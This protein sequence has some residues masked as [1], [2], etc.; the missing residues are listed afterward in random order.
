MTQYRSFLAWPNNLGSTTCPNTR[1][2]P[3]R[4]TI[5]DRLRTPGDHRISIRS[6][7]CHLHRASLRTLCQ[8]DRGGCALRRLTE[9]REVTNHLVILG[10]APVWMVMA[11]V[12]PVRTTPYLVGGPEGGVPLGCRMTNGQDSGKIIM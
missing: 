8:V 12:L 1:L 6:Q 5:L 9:R 2:G 4:G 10:M 11:W 7:S 3:S